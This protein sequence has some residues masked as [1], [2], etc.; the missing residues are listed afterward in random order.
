L[1]YEDFLKI[2]EAF[3]KTSS[4]GLKLGNKMKFIKWDASKPSA[5]DNIILLSKSES[6]KHFELRNSN[7]LLNFYGEETYNRVC[8]ILKKLKSG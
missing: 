8:S 7:D 3:G 6:N 4:I 5:I 2:A 1:I